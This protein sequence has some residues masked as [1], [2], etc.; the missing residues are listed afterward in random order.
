M[1]PSSHGD[2]RYLMLHQRHMPGLVSQIFS[3]LI[4][5]TVCGTGSSP[6]PC[7]T[8][9]KQVAKRLPMVHG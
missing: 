9:D 6:T 4:R 1:Y 7:G 2:K 8:S 5:V 3:S